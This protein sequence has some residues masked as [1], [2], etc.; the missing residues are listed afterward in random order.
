M[1]I[2]NMLTSVKISENQIT[3]CDKVVDDKTQ[4]VSVDKF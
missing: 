1:K 3:D 2:F 4:S